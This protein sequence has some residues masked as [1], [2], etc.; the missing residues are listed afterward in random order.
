VAAEKALRVGG[1]EIT[2]ARGEGN[3][4]ISRPG[5]PEEN[6]DIRCEKID[7]DRASVLFVSRIKLL[8]VSQLSAQERGH[9]P[10]AKGQGVR[11]WSRKSL[12][13]I[14]KV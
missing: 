5:G 10:K 2:G 7:V 1:R 4:H 9:T 14:K 6:A 8:R 12:E 13:S 11:V 3:E